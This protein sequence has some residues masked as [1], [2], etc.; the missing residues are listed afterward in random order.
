MNLHGVLNRG[1]GW[2]FLAAGAVAALG[3]A[4]G[5]APSMACVNGEVLLTLVKVVDGGTASADA[6]T[7]D[8]VGTIAGLTDFAAGQNGVN[9]PVLNGTYTLSESPAKTANYTSLGWKCDNSVGYVT[10]VTINNVANANVTCTI[11]NT[12][13]PHT[14][15][16][17]LVKSVNN[18]AGGSALARDWTLD[19][20]GPTAFTAG[21]SGV[22]HQVLDGTYTLSE[23]PA[24][25]AN[26]SASS[27][28]CTNT[29][30][31]GTT[32]VIGLNDTA[33]TCTITN[34]FVQ[35]F[36]PPV[37]AIPDT[38]ATPSPVVAGVVKNAPV[39][40]G[41]VKSAPVK[42]LAF[43]GAETVPLGLSGLIALVLGAVLTVAS[44]RQRPK[45]ARE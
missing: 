8:A 28:D 17:T 32:V 1:H 11:T 13:V 41:V 35:T 39:V 10:T 27:W 30:V 24:T 22:N 19:A 16:L 2:R 9:H 31:N 34:T 43:T 42:T 33:V 26:Y 12:Y 23:S 21:Q 15:L 20:T 25:T 18:D 4:I 14:A 37:T 29:T 38:P 6:W 44:R 40:A 36:R 45:Q 7:L 3:L 5:A